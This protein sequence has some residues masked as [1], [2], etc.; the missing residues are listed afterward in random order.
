MHIM[1][2]WLINLLCTQLNKWSNKNA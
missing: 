2:L 1:K